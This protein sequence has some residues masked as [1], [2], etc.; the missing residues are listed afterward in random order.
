MPG[1][2]VL[3]QAKREIPSL[4]DVKF[5]VRVA[6]DVNVPAQTGFLDGHLWGKNRT[7]DPPQAD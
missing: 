1:V 2:I 4:S 3:V 7:Y 5:S 6:Q